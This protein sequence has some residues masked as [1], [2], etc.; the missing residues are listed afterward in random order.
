MQ[1]ATSLT[2]TIARSELPDDP[3]RAAVRSVFQAIKA[4]FGGKFQRQ[5]DRREGSASE[6]TENGWCWR[7]YERTKAFR[8]ESV[9][10]GYER[11]VKHHAPHMPILSEIAD[12]ARAIDNERTRTA[13][14][15]AEVAAPRVNG[16]AGYV[17]HLAAANPDNTLAL[18]CIE[19]MREI[20]ARDDA[21]NTDERN[22]RLDKAMKAHEQIMAMAPRVHHRGLPKVCPVPGCGQRGAI[23]RTTHSDGE[24]TE[25]FCAEHFRNG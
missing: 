20:V 13:E 14:H 1:A 9:I 8:P 21:A 24:T 7:L 25:Y 17:E 19:T 15:I 6:L 23:A 18:G 4:D 16:L 10:D 12:A 3:V 11:A 5:F 2:P 22:A